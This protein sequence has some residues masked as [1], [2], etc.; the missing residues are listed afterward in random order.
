MATLPTQSQ[1]HEPTAGAVT[2]VLEG[3]PADG[4][5]HVSPGRIRCIA[6]PVRSVGSRGYH[7]VRYVDSGRRTE[8]KLR[9]TEAPMR[10]HVGASE[11]R[12]AQ[13]TPD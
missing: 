10:F 6:I 11:C 7:A 2:I 5:T 8:W 9:R 1:M 13:A 12:H 4:A 3:G